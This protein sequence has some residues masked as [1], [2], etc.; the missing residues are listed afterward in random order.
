MTGH[1]SSTIRESGVL[2]SGLHTG[3]VHFYNR[4]EDRAPTITDEETLPL[5]SSIIDKLFYTIFDIR[6]VVYP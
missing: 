1:E 6:H 5:R 4:R 3:D 2:R